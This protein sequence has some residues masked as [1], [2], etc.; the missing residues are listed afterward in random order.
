MNIVPRMRNIFYLILSISVGAVL[1][2]LL[3]FLHTQAHALPSVTTHYLYATLAGAVFGLLVYLFHKLVRKKY[4][5]R[6]AYEEKKKIRTYLDIAASIIVAVG[7]NQEV[8]FINR[9]GLEIIGLPLSKVIDKNWF[10]LVIPEADRDREKQAHNDIFAGNEEAIALINHVQNV[11]SEIL[12]KRGRRIIIWNKILE[13]DEKGTPTSVISAGQDISDL[14]KAEEVI[15]KLEQFPGED[16]NPVVRIGI[17]GHFQYSNRAG[18]NV[19]AKWRQTTTAE[20]TQAWIKEITEIIRKGEY[21]EKEIALGK[22]IYSL[23]IIPVQEYQ[24]AILYAREITKH[25]KVAE[26]L[27]KSEARLRKVL[28]LVP[29]MICAKDWDGRIVLANESFAHGYRRTPAELEGLRQID[30]HKNK[31]DAERRRQTDRQVIESGQPLFLPDDWC[32]NLEGEL[33][34][35][36]T[37]K[38]P[39]EYEGK[40]VALSLGIDVTERKKAEEAI[41][42]ARNRAEN[43]LDIAEVMLAALDINGTIILINKKGARAL[44]YEQEELVG[45]NWFELLIPAEKKTSIQEVFQ[46]ILNGESDYYSFYENILTRKTGEERLFAFHN[47]LTKNSSG[48]V[49]GVLFSAE[50]IT[51]RKQMETR[52][53]Q[54]EKMQ[55]IGQLAG[56]IAHDFNNQLAGIIG[57]ADLLH[58]RLEDNKLKHYAHQ[59]L[60]SSKRAADLTAQLLAFSRK[61]KYLS[62]VV[63]LNKLIGEVISLLRHGIDK[64]IEI[65]KNL[66]KEPMLTAGDPTQL[67][68]VI[69]NV[70]LNARDAMPNGGE[71]TFTTD[72]IAL[73]EYHCR[74]HTDRITP[75]RYIQL[76]IRDTG[77]GMDKE[78]SKRIFEPFF[79]TKRAGQG[80]GMGLAAAYGVI[81]NHK[82]SINVYSEL[83]RGT[84]FKIYLPQSLEEETIS[85]PIQETLVKAERRA[86]I[87]IVDD[88]ETVREATTDILEGIGYQV[89]GFNDGN[90]ALEHYRNSWRNIDLVIL[91]I[92]MPKLGGYEILTAMKEINPDISGILSSGYSIDSNIQPVLDKNH[93]D[94]IQKPFTASKL[95][96]TVA[97]LLHSAT[98]A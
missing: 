31:A 26:E 82:G 71:L 65:K 53:I 95:S 23:T 87:L 96:Q 76:T 55:A 75:G 21:R 78:T 4:S 8:T 29:H 60:T 16:P 33:R 7:K 59:V 72:R 41:R 89:I 45:K 48:Q 40:T 5:L 66:A 58:S 84:E 35:M 13:R 92:I 44:G 46:I 36:E 56:G 25:Y 9:K 73:D 57:Y 61:G 22:E 34:N 98:K 80:V 11:R 62:V 50:D 70:S 91:D 47:T 94:F 43:Y 52:L 30:I 38:L 42:E 90:S 20:R 79:T 54:T 97:K 88:E 51:D 85:I 24:H 2:C 68:N 14:S 10:D 67:Q 69:L 19:I 81:R 1:F 18:L 77:I 6:I 83:G 3:L 93:V 39:F 17:D 12:T 86:N 27:Q 37:T 64:K 28:D 15:K 63:D 49:T 74:E 32:L